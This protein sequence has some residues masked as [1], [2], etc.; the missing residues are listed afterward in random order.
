MVMSCIH[1]YVVK[2]VEEVTSLWEAWLKVCEWMCS[3]A[4]SM[5]FVKT[6]EY[7]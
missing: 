5:K 2:V 1:V 6:V 7:D 4:S 3:Q